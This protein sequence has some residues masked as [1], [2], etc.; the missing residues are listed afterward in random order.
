MTVHDGGTIMCEPRQSQKMIGRVSTVTCIQGKEDISQHIQ[1]D[2]R[3]N[4][5]E[6]TS[7][8]ERQS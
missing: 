7:E 3:I 4:G 2:W 5:Y 8:I 6:V 1:D